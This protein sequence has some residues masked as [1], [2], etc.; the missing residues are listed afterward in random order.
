MNW[1]HEEIW[2]QNSNDGDLTDIRVLSIEAYLLIYINLLPCSSK[3]DLY[4]IYYNSTC[5]RQRML[6]NIE[7]FTIHGYFWNKIIKSKTMNLLYIT[8]TIECIVSLIVLA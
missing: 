3:I 8:K 6:K 5:I 7:I 2:V 1:S 4:T